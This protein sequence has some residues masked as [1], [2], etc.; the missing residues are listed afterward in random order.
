MEITKAFVQDWLEKFVSEN[1]Y[2]DTFDIVFAAM[3]EGQSKSN[4]EKELLDNWFENTFMEESF[5]DLKEDLEELTKTSFE[6]FE[7]A[8]CNGSYYGFCFDYWYSLS[9]EDKEKFYNAHKK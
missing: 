3:K 7:R 5:C 6:E 4:N 2:A 1:P 9:T 8:G